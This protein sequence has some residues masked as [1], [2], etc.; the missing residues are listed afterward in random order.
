MLHHDRGETARMKSYRVAQLL[1]IFASIGILCG[2]ATL[3]IEPQIAVTPYADPYAGP[4]ETLGIVVLSVGA[5]C[6]LLAIVAAIVGGG[7]K[8]TGT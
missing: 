3:G 5:L 1:A 8:N 7:S 6:L 4:L 2:C